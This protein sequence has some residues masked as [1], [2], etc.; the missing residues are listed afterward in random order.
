MSYRSP[1]ERVRARIKE[2]KEAHGHGSQR[3]LAEQ[4]G[5]SDSWISG[6]MSRAQELRLDD[7]DAL[8]K[9]MGV[10]PGDLVRRDDD[11]YVEVIPS[12]FRFLKHLRTLPEPVRRHCLALLDHMAELHARV[13]EGDQG[14]RDKSRPSR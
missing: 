5:K 4:A 14:T 7:L 13:R 3:R 1:A 10:P 12:E 9:G 6:I 8:A 2:W 11:L